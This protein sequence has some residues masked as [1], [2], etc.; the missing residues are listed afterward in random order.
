MRDERHHSVIVDY[1]APAIERV[2]DCSHFL[3]LLLLIL[4]ISFT[5]LFPFSPQK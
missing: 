3:I 1:L 2:L 4:L 5:F